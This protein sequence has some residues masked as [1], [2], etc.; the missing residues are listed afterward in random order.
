[1]QEAAESVA[2]ANVSLTGRGAGR[3]GFWDRRLLAECAVWPVRVVVVRGFAQHALKMPMRDDQDPIETLTPDAADPALRMRFRLRRRDRCANHAD[4]FQAEKGVARSLVASNVNTRGR[5]F[6]RMSPTTAIAPVGPTLASFCAEFALAP[7]TPNTPPRRQ[8]E[9]ELGSSL[10][11][12]LAERDKADAARPHPGRSV[13][14]EQSAV[15]ELSGGRV[16]DDGV[17]SVA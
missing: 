5:R 2:S 13:R 9:Q 12:Q 6:G 1:V 10:Q 3:G 7:Q 17:R 8:R 14:V 11:G 4:P 15:A 16:G